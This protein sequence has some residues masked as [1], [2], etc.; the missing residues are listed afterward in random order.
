MKVRVRGFTLIELLIVVAIIAI[1]A[2]IAVP[3]FLEAQV[4]SKV[5][6][7]KADERTYATSVESY[8][9]DWNTYPCP[10]FDGDGGLGSIC[11]LETS[12]GHLSTPI[13]YLTTA[14]LPEPFNGK[15][16]DALFAGCDILAGRVPSS[17]QIGCDTGQP[18]YGYVALPNDGI[19]QIALPI[20]FN[21][22][23]LLPPPYNTQ[24]LLD[25]TISS[26]IRKRWAV[27]SP[28]PDTYFTYDYC[29]KIQ[30]RGTLECVFQEIA[31]ATVDSIG[32][33]YDPTNGTVS[34][35]EVVRTG[36][37]IPFVR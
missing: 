17:N 30:N 12:L 27:V 24:P 31:D 20:L 34:Q 35:G 36:E 26:V 16:G 8:Y 33:I 10:L 13:A 15:Q 3:N 23:S 32:G 2:A 21:L 9:V 1:L 25:E 19:I 22:A 6:R 4:R 29:T 37:G 28:G 18:I 5:S 14:Y 7:V 11:P